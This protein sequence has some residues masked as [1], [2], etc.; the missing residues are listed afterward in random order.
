MYGNPETTTGGR[1]LKFYASVRI[2]VRKADVLKNGADA[3]GNHVKCKVVK[4]KVAPPFRQ[5]EF[6][7]FYDSGISQ[8]NEIIDVAVDKEI[9]RK[10]G[11]WFSYNG[12]NIGQGKEKTK[13]YLKNNPEVFEEI[14]NKILSA[15]ADEF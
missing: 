15:P 13:D 11:A 4:N 9:I 2:E 14:K 1:A 7:I 8:E 12:E 6:D 3:Y 10:S 5:A